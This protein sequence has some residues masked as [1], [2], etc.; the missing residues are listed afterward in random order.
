[1]KRG[2]LQ[3][4]FAW[5]FGIIVGVAILFFA[6]YA[7]VKLIDVGKYEVSS[8]TAKNIE[9]LLNPLETGFET[10]VSTSMSLDRET[11]IYNNCNNEDYFGHQIISI[12]QKSFGKW[13]NPTQ[14]TSSS[15]KYIF[16][17]NISEGKKFYLFSKPFDFPFKVGDLIYLIPASKQYCFINPPEEIEEEI[18]SLKENNA[19]LNLEIECSDN[20]IKVCFEG[21]TDCDILVKYN[22][23]Y[24]KKDGETKYFEGN[25]LMYAAIFSDKKTYECQVKRLMQRIEQLAEIYRD[26]EGFISG[27]GCDP[28]LTADLSVLISLTKSLENSQDLIGINYFVEEIQQKNEYAE[29]RL[30]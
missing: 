19:E 20:A 27:K 9:V 14:G 4:S 7:S 13:S 25:A 16:S 26:K 3:I 29:C 6:I 22:Q 5:I 10:A 24:V 15:N 11:R 1:M 23:K 2:Y 30:W 28:E 18:S 17:E 8:E 12:S 21:G